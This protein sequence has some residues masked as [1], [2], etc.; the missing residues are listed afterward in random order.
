LSLV[1]YLCST[2]YTIISPVSYIFQCADVGT[3]GVTVGR[4]SGL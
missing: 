2:A 3:V 1:L 4:A